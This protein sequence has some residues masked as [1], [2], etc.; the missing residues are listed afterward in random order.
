M[1]RPPRPSSATPKPAVS[2]PAIVSTRDSSEL[3]VVGGGRLSKNL[4]GKSS[5]NPPTNLKLKERPKPENRKA[6][7]PRNVTIDRYEVISAVIRIQRWFRRL[8]RK[9][10]EKQRNLVKEMLLKK[11]EK[12]EAERIASRAKEV[13]E[14]KLELERMKVVCLFVSRS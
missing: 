14:S 7:E 9:W 1:F 10:A 13:E 5:F 4:P 11:R 8:S 3:R 12:L 2:T 6:A